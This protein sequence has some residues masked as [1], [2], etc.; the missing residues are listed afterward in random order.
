MT[1]T[2]LIGS[3]AND[4]WVG[5]TGDDTV[6]GKGGADTLTGGSGDDIMF[7]DSKSGGMKTPVGIAVNEDWAAKITFIT[8]SAGHRNALGMYVINP[9]GS[10]TDVRILFANAS[11]KGSGGDLIGKVSSVMAELKA[12][13]RIAFFIAPDGFSKSAAALTNPGASFELRNSAGELARVSD[14]ADVVLQSVSKEGVRSTIATANTN[15]LFFSDKAMNADGIEHVRMKVD[16]VKGTVEI[17]FEDL[18]GGGDRDFDDVVFSVDVGV[19][20][21][22]TWRAVDPPKVL[23]NNNDE[24]RAG[25]GNDQAYGGAGN[26]RLWGESGNDLL[27]GG[28]G[29]DSLWGGIGNDTL[30]GGS[31]DDALYGEDGNDLVEGG[32]GNDRIW[33]GA[34]ADT[35]F[36]GSGRD[37]VWAGAGDDSYNGGAGYDILDFSGARTALTLDMSKKTAVGDLG[38]DSF[39]GFEHIVGTR[40][41]DTMRGDKDANVLVGGD[42]DDVFRG[43]GGADVFTGGKGR[44]TVSISPKDVWFEGVHFGVDRVTD[45]TLGE[46]KLDLYEITKNHK[47]DRFELIRLEQVGKDV[48][49]SADLGMDKGGVQ[50]LVILEGQ[51]AAKLAAVMGDWLT[52]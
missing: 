2:G 42:G 15:T 37:I 21:A 46:D 30:R 32:A 22:E 6:F 26:D 34:G 43:L 28:S 45:F 19:R 11:L 5:S 1:M 35:V 7:G 23:A 20:N 12:G 10:I 29:N 49:V 39:G 17:G 16:A 8:E 9:D 14:G 27:D 40:F 33:D 38:T 24:L 47:G 3:L 44:D 25:I 36:G 13:Q 50:K 48:H 41:N 51:D 4:T 31:G 52:V 18:L